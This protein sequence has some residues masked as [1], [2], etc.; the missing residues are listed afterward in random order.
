MAPESIM[1][2]GANE[3]QSFGLTGEGMVFWDGAAMPSLQ[4]SIVLRLTVSSISET[5]RVP[6]K[7][8]VLASS[9]SS[10]RTG[11]CADLPAARDEGLVAVAKKSQQLREPRRVQDV[12]SITSGLRQIIGRRESASHAFP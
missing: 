11:F 4:E 3:V 10:M 9:S 1:S 5:D 7:T 8:T 2:D 6:G 12:N